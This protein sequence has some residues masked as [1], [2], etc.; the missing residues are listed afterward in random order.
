VL[1]QKTALKIYVQRSMFVHFA[2]CESVGISTMHARPEFSLKISATALRSIDSGAELI[3]AVSKRGRGLDRRRLVRSHS[4]VL[5]LL[6]SAWFWVPVS[7]SLFAFGL[8]VVLATIIAKRSEEISPDPNRVPP[9]PN[10]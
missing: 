10:E 2:N 3:H 6:H 1:L 5:A 7:T 9:F 8:I 4:L